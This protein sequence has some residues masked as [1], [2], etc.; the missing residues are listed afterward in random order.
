MV[1]MCCSGGLYAVVG[2]GIENF[3][4]TSGEAGD[5]WI[6]SVCVAMTEK[7][8]FAESVVVEP[9]A[10]V[11]PEYRE[12]GLAVGETLMRVLNL[13]TKDAWIELFAVGTNDKKCPS[14][15]CK[16]AREGAIFRALTPLVR[17]MA[18]KRGAV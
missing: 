11:P 2:V 13:P 3:I 1:A 10:K 7:G 5:A 6:D 4:D 8:Y 14:R 9:C 12:R 15:A 16:T 18:L 17:D